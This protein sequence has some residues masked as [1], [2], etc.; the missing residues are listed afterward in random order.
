VPGTYVQPVLLTSPPGDPR[1]FVVEQ[2][3]TI[4]IVGNPTPFM[5]VTG[6]TTGGERGLLGL[7][8]APDYATSR[9]F[10]LNYTNG[11][12]DTVIE[13]VLASALDPDLADTTTRTPLLTIDQPFSNH[14]GGHLAFGPDGFLYVGMGDGGSGGDPLEAAQTPS[15]HLGKMLRLDVSGATYTIPAGNPYAAGGGAAENWALGLRNPWR[16][17]FDRETGDLYIGDVGQGQWEEIDVTV[18][19]TT[20]PV[21]YGWDDMEGLHCYEPSSGCLM[22]GRALPV[23]EY[24]HAGGGCSITGGYVYRGCR[25]PGHHG[26]YFFADY[27]SGVVT[28]LR[29]DAAT[30]T[31]TS[32]TARPALSGGN[33]SSFGEDA[34]GEIYILRHGGSIV[35]IVPL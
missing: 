7:A 5:T 14:N 4:R 10:Y 28:S 26:T 13:R 6:I 23:H 1:L 33:V 25:M 18:A 22:A 27:C 21:N 12:G 34:L 8:F 16:W 17:S 30:G 11:A 29:F 15:S 31:A 24:S 19:G 2:G 35:K 3:G 20:P 32:I 9:R